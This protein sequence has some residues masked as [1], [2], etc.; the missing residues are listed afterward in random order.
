MNQLLQMKC[1][2][3]EG[4]ETPLTHDEIQSLLKRLKK[5]WEVL[6]DKKIR[7]VFTFKDFREAMT[8]VNKVADIAEAEQ[9]HPD[10]HIFY[11]K[12]A[13]E[14]WTH[15]I[16]GLYQNDFIVAAKIDEIMP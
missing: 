13:I 12:V 3:C 16:D 4:A 9:H 5:P 7:K 2:A 8:F 14:L 15:A 11:N 6:N 10:I 1:I